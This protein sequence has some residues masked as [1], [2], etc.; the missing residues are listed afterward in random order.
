MRRVSQDV[1]DP[2]ASLADDRVN[3]RLYGVLLVMRHLLLSIESERADIVDVVDVIEARSAP[4]GISLAQLGFPEAWRSSPIWARDFV[5]ESSP[6][7]AADLLDRADSLT[8]PQA[9]ATLTAAEPKA[10]D[11]PRTPEQ[12]AAAK[13]GAQKAL[14][15]TYLKYGVVIEVELGGTK[16]Y[17]AFQFRDGR[18]IDALAEINKTLASSCGDSDPTGVARA[19]LDWWQ[20]PHPDLPQDEDGSDRS[21]LDL[22]GSV[23]EGEFA[24]AIDD[25]N[26]TGSFAVPDRGCT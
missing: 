1:R 3:N 7:V 10:K 19:L 16:F 25:A 13:R 23:A 22:L 9:R 5:L 2:L 21:P 20:T 12:L 4:L 17:P 24:A 11:E 14:L 18:I 6:M 26:A 8:A 15:R